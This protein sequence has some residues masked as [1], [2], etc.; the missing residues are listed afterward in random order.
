M[1]YCFLLS[2]RVFFW[3]KNIWIFYLAFKADFCS[4][5]VVINTCFCH[6]SIT[7]KQT[8]CDLNAW[9]QKNHE[10]CTDTVIGLRLEVECSLMPPNCTILQKAS[11]DHVCHPEKFN[12]EKRDSF[13]TSPAAAPKYFSSMIFIFTLFVIVIF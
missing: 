11:F 8:D 10:A 4:R 6:F 12:K 1:E 2:S 5:S 3:Q 7:I 9:S 13:R